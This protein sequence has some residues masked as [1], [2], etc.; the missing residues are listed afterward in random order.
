MS[1]D[2]M[3]IFIEETEGNVKEMERLVGELANAD[4]E[5]LGYMRR[6][7]HTVKGSSAIMGFNT[8][9]E[10]AKYVED[11][12]K[13]LEAGSLQYSDD[14]GSLLADGVKGLRNEFESVRSSGADGAEGTDDLI[15]RY[16]ANG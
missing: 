6:C 4:N 8:M 5:T 14:L 7:A 15:Q 9:S 3:K 13:R 2:L 10:L 12:F 1:A 16:K 11:V